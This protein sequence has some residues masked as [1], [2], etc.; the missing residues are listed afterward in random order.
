MVVAAGAEERGLRARTSTLVARAVAVRPTL[1]CP[2]ASG[3]APR[4][5]TS[6]VIGC[7]TWRIVRSPLTVQTLIATFE[8]PLP[9]NLIAGKFLTS[10]NRALRR[11]FGLVTAVKRLGPVRVAH[12]LAAQPQLLHKSDQIVH[13]V[14]LDDL[15]II[16][17]ADGVEIDVERLAS[18]RDLRAV[19]AQHRPGHRA[20]EPRDRTC[21]VAGGEEHLLRSVVQMLVGGHLPKTRSTRP[22]DLRSRRSDLAAPASGQSHRAYGVPQKRRHPNPGVKFPA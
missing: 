6:S 18:G 13:E 17:L 7:V 16:P 19:R 8:P 9:R 10:K 5:V 1:T 20:L 2:C 22:C 21:P 14:L 12:E 4:T 15:S 11:S 3:L